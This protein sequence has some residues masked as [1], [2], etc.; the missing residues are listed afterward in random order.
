MLLTWAELRDLICKMTPVQRARPAA[1]FDSNTGE[2]LGF[3]SIEK[4][5][6][7]AEP[8]HPEQYCLLISDDNIPEE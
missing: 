7:C 2:T 4:A 5:V 1:V 8:N 6:D 3:E